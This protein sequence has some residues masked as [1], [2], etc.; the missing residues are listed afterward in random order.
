M[1]RSPDSKVQTYLA[2]HFERVA[3]SVFRCEFGGFKQDSR[4]KQP[5][6]L[7]REE[8]VRTLA[9]VTGLHHISDLRFDDRWITEGGDERSRTISSKGVSSKKKLLEAQRCFGRETQARSLLRCVSLRI[10]AAHR[11]SVDMPV[12]GNR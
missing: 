8:T 3:T 12:S 11:L 5:R 2:P 4:L 6:T 10:G 1:S 7:S 9:I